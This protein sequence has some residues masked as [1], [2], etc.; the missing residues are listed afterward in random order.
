MS[1]DIINLRSFRKQ[2]RRDE[3]EQT[4][5]EN[6][7]RHG[8]TKQEKARDLRE[9]EKADREIDGHKIEEADK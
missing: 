2:K 3:K 9:S 7:I 4:A 1:A 5:E 6:R 8:R